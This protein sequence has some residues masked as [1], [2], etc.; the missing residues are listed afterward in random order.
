VRSGRAGRGPEHWSAVQPEDLEA[1]ASLSWARRRH[2]RR[3]ARRSGACATS[4]RAIRRLRPGLR[5]N[6]THACPRRDLP[7]RLV[8]RARRRD[9]RR[10]QGRGPAQDLLTSSPSGHGG[11]GPVRARCAMG[12]F[13]SCPAT[14]WRGTWCWQARPG[15]RPSD[16][17]SRATCSGPARA[18][19]PRSPRVPRLSGRD[20]GARPD[21]RGNATEV[22]AC[23]D[24]GPTAASRS[25]RR[26]CLVHRDP[27]RPAPPPTCHARRR[28]AH[29]WTKR[30]LAASERGGAWRSS[31]PPGH[32]ALPTRRRTGARRAVAAAAW[33]R[34]AWHAAARVGPGAARPWRSFDLPGEPMLRHRTCARRAP[35]ARLDRSLRAR[36]ALVP[37]SSHDVKARFT[38]LESCRARRGP[39]GD[40][41]RR[42]VLRESSGW[43]AGGRA[44]Q[45]RATPSPS[46]T[47]FELTWP[48][49][50][51]C[52]AHVVV[53]RR[54]EVTFCASTPTPRR[55][56]RRGPGRRVTG[57]TTR[58]GRLERRRGQAPGPPSRPLEVLPLTLDVL[59]RAGALDRP[60]LVARATP[61]PGAGPPPAPRGAGHVSG[62]RRPSRAHAA[63]ATDVDR[64]HPSGSR[65]RQRGPAIEPDATVPAA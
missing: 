23:V 34:T 12:P 37:R 11:D 38:L 9:V 53:T 20:P 65:P 28:A 61:R 2:G 17:S 5:D 41:C 24:H 64:Q 46:P 16:L 19:A 26:S 15:R 62:S 33:C 8:C 57:A 6:P 4:S 50:L 63:H 58:L 55:S 18:P 43:A 14:P 7:R 35:G 29:G 48:S 3:G 40:R 39:P 30:Y 54:H 32:E 59:E 13:A 56:T 10:A 45:V 36:H 47:L 51:G 1:K 27:G 42:D 49:W 22:T 60:A 31:W 21:L 52:P 25:W 44:L